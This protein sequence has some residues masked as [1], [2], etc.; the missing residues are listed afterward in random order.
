[1][2]VWG[3]IVVMMIAAASALA[4]AGGASQ[5]VVVPRVVGLRLSKAEQVLRVRGLRAG[6]G[7]RYAPNVSSSGSLGV[8]AVG[9]DAERRVTVQDVPAGTRVPKHSVI[10]LATARLSRPAAHDELAPLW[11][12]FGWRIDADDRTLTLNVRNVGSSQLWTVQ[13]GHRFVLLSHV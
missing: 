8:L 4:A 10:E 9:V 2:A 11:W 1:M 7:V 12:P 3:S 6:N 5:R 13:S